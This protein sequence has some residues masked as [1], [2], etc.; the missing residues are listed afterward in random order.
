MSE[1]PLAENPTRIDQ[2][3]QKT[4]TKS[5]KKIVATRRRRNQDVLEKQ[6]PMKNAPMKNAPMKNA[7]M[8]SAPMKNAPMKN[9][10]MK[11]S[12]RFGKIVVCPIP[13]RPAN[14]KSARQAVSTSPK[15]QPVTIDSSDSENEWAFPERYGPRINRK[16]CKS[17]SV[18]SIKKQGE[19]RNSKTSG[20]LKRFRGRNQWK[21]EILDWEFWNTLDKKTKNVNS[22]LPGNFL[23]VKL[24]DL[25]TATKIRSA[26]NGG[27][28]PAE[29]S[30][31]LGMQSKNQKDFM[32]SWLCTVFF[33]D[34]GTRSSNKQRAMRFRTLDCIAKVTYLLL[35]TEEFLSL[36]PAALKLILNRVDL[37]IANEA[38]LFNAV[39]SWGLYKCYGRISGTFVGSSHYYAAMWEVLK[40]PLNFI[41]FSYSSDYSSPFQIIP[42]QFVLCKKLETILTW[43]KQTVQQND[44]RN[45]PTS[46]GIKYFHDKAPAIPLKK[47]LMD[48][49]TS[50]FQLQFEGPPEKKIS[51]RRRGH[52]YLSYYIEEWKQPTLLHVLRRITPFVSHVVIL[53]QNNAE[54]KTLGKLVGPKICSQVHTLRVESFEQDRVAITNCFCADGGILITPDTCWEIDPAHNSVLIIYDMPFR[55]VKSSQKLGVRKVTG[56]NRVVIYFFKATKNPESDAAILSNLSG[57][58]SRLPVNFEID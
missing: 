39:T 18:P 27:D 7:P 24:I 58:M 12:P 25:A 19:P 47:S 23:K 34:F 51:L 40:G 28:H 42:P 53:C 21:N 13:R 11:N 26:F 57:N 29:V 9:A 36:T 33:E 54:V 55:N 48:I 32:A 14:L 22:A 44:G 17:L 2:L 16:K 4:V 1:S 3:A 43:F 52:F 6:A 35:D 20:I 46:T 5:S 56:H 41:R 45:I 37:T 10:P 30:T 38:D 15:L 50:L 31:K 8:K 49:A